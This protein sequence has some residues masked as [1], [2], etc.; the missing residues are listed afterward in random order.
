MPGRVR[1]CC[2]IE[3]ASTCLLWRKAA[4]PVRRYTG[5]MSL[6][7]APVSGKKKKKKKDAPFKPTPDTWYKRRFLIMISPAWTMKILFISKWP[8]KT[9]LYKKKKKNYSLR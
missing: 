1:G 7:K 3:L 5:A 6:Q 4:V 9:Q 8:C 2:H